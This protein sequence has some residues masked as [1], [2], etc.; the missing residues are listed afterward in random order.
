[1]SEQVLAVGGTGPTG[2]FIIDG[3]RNRGCQVTI[4]HRGNHEVAGQEDLEHIHGDPHFADTIAEA[5]GDRRFDTVLGMYGRTALVADHFAARGTARRFIGIGSFL[6]YAGWVN[7]ESRFPSGPPVGV[8]EDGP[9]VSDEDVETWPSLSFSKK[10]A[11]TEQSVMAHHRPGT[12]DVTWMRYG[13]VYGPGSLTPWEWSVVK[14]VQDERPFMVINSDGLAI[15]SRIYAMNAAHAVLLAFDQPGV[16]AGQ[17]YNCADDQQLT[18]R[19][20]INTAARA[21][22]G[23]LELVSMP[24]EVAEPAWFLLPSHIDAITHGL[25]D[26]TK[27]RQQLGYR[28]LVPADV[29]IRETVE[30]YLAHP[31]TDEEFPLQQDHFRYD[32]EDRLVGKYRAMIAELQEHGDPST[33]EMFHPT[34]HP[35][36][37]TGV[38]S[39]A[40]GR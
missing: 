7:P 9:K 34:P 33:R 36:E 1:M 6:G 8:A 18:E 37:S 16:A 35:R 32:V 13:V 12:F 25:V 28:D 19:Q 22:G 3:L 2:R 14:R 40:R 5:L 23:A 11:M 30:H 21:A 17:V 29:A 24:W 31:V 4:F 27:I 15:R 38:R 20:W 26:T 39:D 10:I